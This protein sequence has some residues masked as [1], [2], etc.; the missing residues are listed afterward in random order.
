[1]ATKKLEIKYGLISCDSHAQLDKDNWLK[2]MSKAKWGDAIPQIKQTSDKS[3]LA[4]DWGDKVFDRWFVNGV[5]QGNRGV[6][7]C[8]TV[9]QDPKW[10]EAGAH[11]KYFPQHWEDVP[12]YVY[13][14]VKRLSALDKDGVDA[15]VLFQNDP[16][17]GARFFQ[18]KDPAFELEATKAY[19]DGVA[20]WRQ[21][22]ERYIPLAVP[23]Y[24]GG[25][26]TTVAE[27][28]RSTKIGHRG[29][30]MLAE[31]QSAGVGLPHFNDL[32]WEPL[33]ASAQDLGV[34]IHWHGSGGLNVAGPQWKGYTRNEEQAYGPTASFSAVAQFIPNLIFSGNLNRY[35]RLKWV[36][37]ETGLGWVNYIL[38]GCDHE[39]ERRHLWTEGIN[40]RPSDMFRRQL[41]VDF[42]YEKA[43]VEMRHNIG[44]HNIMW[45]S[46]YPHSTS[47]WP[48]S[49]DFVNR[50]LA[51]VP[52][53]DR[54][55]MTWKNAYELYYTS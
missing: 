27:F 45:E 36:C 18:G 13:D 4:V 21:V 11:R 17:Q 38:E 7:N 37:A 48:E 12:D 6:S 23:A 28:E 22:S 42:W 14:P 1:V 39:W 55:L 10:G 43:G 25:I 53:E 50:T 15:E 20:E 47:T 33:W 24:L 16:V 40:E 35:P 30:V 29:L 3:Y 26:E 51:A 49:W 46:D 19:N 44:I 5:M 2:R 8:P 9:M 31:P 52:Q 41:Y 34:A 32:Y 54:D